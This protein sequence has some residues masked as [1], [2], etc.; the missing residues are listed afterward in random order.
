DDVQ[1]L[2]GVDLVDHRRERRRLAA[3]G[4]PR[5]EHEPARLVRELRDDR[6]KPELLERED[7]ERNRTKRARDVVA[8]HEDVGA[9]TREPAHAER[10]VELVV[11][12]E[13]NLLLFGQNRVAEALGVDRLELRQLE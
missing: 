5:H 10:E 12:L 8:L 1:A 9:K 7:L 13:L 6:R 11:L 3:S 2:L 4:G